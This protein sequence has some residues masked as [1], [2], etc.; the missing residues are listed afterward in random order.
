MCYSIHL[1]GGLNAPNR[2]EGEWSSSQPEGAK[3]CG[4]TTTTKVINSAP[5]KEFDQIHKWSQDRYVKCRLKCSSHHFKI[6]M[7]IVNEDGFTVHLYSKHPV[8]AASLVTCS[9]LV[10]A[11]FPPRGHFFSF[12]STPMSGIKRK[13]EK[14]KCM[15]QYYQDF[16]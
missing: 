7:M 5:L 6:W 10:K 12:L 3:A 16:W 9:I 14:T 2:L 4:K 15:L 13:Q 1:N 8:H 11:C